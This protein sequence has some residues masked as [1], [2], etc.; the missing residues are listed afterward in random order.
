MFGSKTTTIPLDWK[1][2]LKIT[3][4]LSDVGK[5]SSSTGPLSVSTNPKSRDTIRG[6]LKSNLSCNKEKTTWHICQGQDLSG[7]ITA[8]EALNQTVL[9][10]SQVQKLWDQSCIDYR[11]VTVHAIIIVIYFFKQLHKINV[12]I[13]HLFF[14]FFKLHS[15]LCQLHSTTIANYT[16]VY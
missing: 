16:I 9:I 4:L 11:C 8:Q 15:R 12:E 7:L 10:S 14:F 1:S 5:A 2:E 3:V 6:S 13:F